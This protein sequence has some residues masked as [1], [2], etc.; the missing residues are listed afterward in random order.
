VPWY[1]TFALVVGAVVVV[2]AVLNRV[3]RYRRAR[4]YNALRR[5]PYSVTAPSD[6]GPIAAVPEF[7]MAT[8]HARMQHRDLCIDIF[9]NVD[10]HIR[11]GDPTETQTTV[12]I[13]LPGPGLPDFTIEPVSAAIE[14]RMKIEKRHG[15]T[16]SGDQ[17]FTDFNLV[18]ATDPEPARHL[19][20]QAD[21]TPLLQRNRTL[22]LESRGHRL[23]LF[24]A[25]RLMSCKRSV[26]VVDLGVEF[27]H[28]LLDADTPAPSTNGATS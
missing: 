7:E 9:E 20:K 14:M 4:V 11:P 24:E 6:R 19:L 26:S 5:H 18:T 2:F 3:H 25:E 1:V 23:V 21:I 17:S 10:F 28:R 15:V 22:T 12:M 8:Y 13:T 27:A 16:V